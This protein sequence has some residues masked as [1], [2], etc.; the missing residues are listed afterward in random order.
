MVLINPDELHTGATAHEAGWRYR[1]F[2]PEHERV[3]GVLDELELGRH[4]MPHFKDSVIRDPALAA[5]FSELHRLSESDAS[6][7]EQQT[8]WRQAVLA[9]VQRHGHGAEAPAPATNRALWPAPANCSKASWPTHRRSKPWPQR[10]TSPLPLRPGVPPGH[11]PATPRLAQAAPPVPRPRAAQERPP[12][13]RSRLRPGFCRP[14]PP[15][16]AIQ[17][18]LWRDAGG[19]SAGVSVRLA[20]GHT[21]Q[22]AAP[23]AGGSMPCVAPNSATQDAPRCVD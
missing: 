23:I 20:P 14:E 4:G 12:R 11:R 21:V 13:L 17:A 2:Y 5:L 15:Q 7:L 18:G 8:A 6:A 1:G 9:L 3:T 19:V 10:S 22:K 16:Q